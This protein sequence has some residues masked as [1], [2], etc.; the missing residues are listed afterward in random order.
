MFRRQFLGASASLALAT[1]LGACAQMGKHPDNTPPIVF[2]HGN[3]DS[4]ACWLTTVG[5][6]ESNG[7]PSDRLFALQ[8]PYPW[9][10]DDDTVEAQAGGEQMRRGGHETLGVVKHRNAVNH[11]ARE[12]ERRVREV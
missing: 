4:F 9:A 5:R 12:I 8:Q 2:L 1:S 6:F 10:R 11:P 3:G 7:W